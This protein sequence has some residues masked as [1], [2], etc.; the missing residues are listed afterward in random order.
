M[1]SSVFLIALVAASAVNASDAWTQLRGPNQGH[2]DAK[3]V[4]LKWSESEHV[5]WKTPL[6]GQGW[7]SPVVSGKQ[8]WMTTALED[9]R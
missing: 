9:G 3:T 5:K 1:K 7:S 4:P 8:V 2:S 6:P